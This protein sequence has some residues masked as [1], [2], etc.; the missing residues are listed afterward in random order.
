VVRYLNTTR[1]TLSRRKRRRFTWTAELDALLEQGYRY[2]RPGRHAAIDRIQRLTGWPRQACWD[3]VR[4]LGLTQKRQNPPR[5]WTA[6][7]QHQLISLV[8]SKN[9]RCI[10]LRLNRSVAAIRTRLKR[11]NQTSVRVRDG[12]TKGELAAL[13]GCSQKT[14]QRWI[15]QGWLKGHYEGKLRPDDTFRISDEHF[16]EFWWR[17]PD[18]APLHRWSREGLEWFLTVIGESPK[19]HERNPSGTKGRDE[20]WTGFAAI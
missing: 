4:K 18:E 11:L 8:G 10:A 14:V 12:L 9:V 15:D 6:A 16:R 1:L 17:H 3:R 2:G 13:I 7:E 20:Q 19:M 5:Q